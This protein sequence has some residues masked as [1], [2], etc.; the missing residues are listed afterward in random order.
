MVRVIV[1]NVERHVQFPPGEWA[2]IQLF[3]GKRSY[4]EIAEDLLAAEGAQYSAEGP[5]VRG[6]DGS[7]DFWYKTPQEK[8]MQLMQMSAEERRK[9]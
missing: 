1:A 9:S 4:E 5:G 6:H 7:V 3:D 2:L 8:N